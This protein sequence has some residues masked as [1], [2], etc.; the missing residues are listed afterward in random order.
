[1]SREL[2]VKLQLGLEQLSIVRE[3]FQPLIHLS[4]EAAGPIET[5]AACAMLH[6]FY[7]EIEKLLNSLPAIGTGSRLPRI[8]GTNNLCFRWRRRLLVGRQSSRSRLSKRS[9]NTWRFGICF[10]EHR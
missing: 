2:A 7:T 8:H 6:S 10:E 5:S 4:A 3:Q 9:A 1:M